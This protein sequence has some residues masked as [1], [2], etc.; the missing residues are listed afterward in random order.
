[1][2]HDVSKGKGVLGQLI[3]DTSAASQVKSIIN[4]LA[5]ATDTLVEITRQLQQF[6]S[7]LNDKNGM[8]HTLSKDSVM[9]VELKNTMEN[10]N[11]SSYNLNE[12]LKA[13]RSNFLFRKYF[14][15]EEKK[16]KKL[17]K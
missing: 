15:E 11:Q 6:S 17:N 8:I 7:G 12:N 16:K 5:Q 1:M 13:M 9:T 14:T 10:I 3:G 4:H 2:I